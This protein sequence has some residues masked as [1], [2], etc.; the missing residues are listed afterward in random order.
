MQYHPVTLNRRKVADDLT[1][2]PMALK[3]WDYMCQTFEDLIYS[4]IHPRDG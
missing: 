1:L 4:F 2:L 3:V